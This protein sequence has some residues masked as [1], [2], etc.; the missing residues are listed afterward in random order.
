MHLVFTVLL[1]VLSIISLSLSLC[2]PFLDIFVPLVFR[3]FR[4]FVLVVMFMLTAFTMS[5][6]ISPLFWLLLFGLSVLS[7][8]L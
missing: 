8:I 4:N 5:L 7:D 6:I 3:K 2:G 1:P